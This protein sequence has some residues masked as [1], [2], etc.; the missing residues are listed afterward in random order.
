MKARSYPYLHISKKYGI[1]YGVILNYAHNCWQ[2]PASELPELPSACR[3]EILNAKWELQLL[4]QGLIKYETAPRID[5]HIVTMDDTINGMS[6]VLDEFA[7]ACGVKTN[8]RFFNNQKLIIQRLVQQW[9]NANPHLFK[10]DV[11]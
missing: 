1:D 10:D 4:A 7:R 9:V 2:R 6:W 3:E 8:A 5:V 11:K